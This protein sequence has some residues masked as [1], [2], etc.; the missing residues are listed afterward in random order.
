MGPGFLCNWRKVIAS[1]RDSRL[2][3]LN[4]MAQSIRSY[5][6]DSFHPCA[7]VKDSRTCVAVQPEYSTM[8]W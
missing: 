4:S 5:W 8:V 7:S 1:G 6:N 2:G 3:L